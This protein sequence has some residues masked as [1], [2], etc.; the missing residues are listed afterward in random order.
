MKENKN[1]TMYRDARLYLNKTTKVTQ[2]II[3]KT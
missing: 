2:S 3:C 1:K